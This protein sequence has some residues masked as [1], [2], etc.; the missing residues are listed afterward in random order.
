MNQQKRLEF[1]RLRARI[2]HH[3]ELLGI[4]LELG[5]AR[6]DLEPHVELLVVL[7]G[8]ARALSGM[9]QEI[10]GLEEKTAELA[11]RVEARPHLQLVR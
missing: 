2:D 4:K 8:N 9:T 5:T 3:L 6:V 10:S 1:H 11:A 7:I